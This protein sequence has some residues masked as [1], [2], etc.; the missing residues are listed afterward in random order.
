MRGAG[1]DWDP[2]SSFFTQQENPERT[3][4]VEVASCGQRK[5]ISV[6]DTTS[7][8]DL[9]GLARRAASATA[10]YSLRGCTAITSFI[11]FRDFA[12]FGISGKLTSRNGAQLNT[13]STYAE[14]QLVSEAQRAEPGVPPSNRFDVSPIVPF[15]V[16]LEDEDKY[17]LIDASHTDQVS[18]ILQRLVE[19]YP[20]LQAL[21]WS[22]H[23]FQLSV[24]IGFIPIG[25][26]NHC[27][28]DYRLINPIDIDIQPTT[29]VIEML[30]SVPD[31]L[32]TRLPEEVAGEPLLIEI[33]VE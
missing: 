12:P 10:P 33:F 32:V 18:D 14:S 9:S 13:K 5:V 25:N 15:R 16:A 26:T 19:K 4:N 20:Y 30:A 21:D 3:Y 6:Y 22:S 29:S 8:R 24:L 23:Q 31:N 1:I 2:K 27:G 7:T 28:M 17:E 11:E